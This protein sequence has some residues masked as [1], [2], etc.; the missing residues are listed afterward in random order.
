MPDRYWVGGTA[1]WDNTVG[2]K[3]SATPGGAGGASVPTSAD[4]VFFD[5]ASGAAVVGIAPGN[6]GARSINCT[7]FT[8]T[9]TGSTNITVSGSITLVAAMTWTHSGI[10]TISGTGTL[11]T[12]G[13]LFS[14][15]TINGAGITVTLGG[16]LDI[17]GRNLTVSQG[18]FTTNGNSITAGTLIS[19]TTSVRTI[20]LGA[21][22]LTL[23]NGVL[24]TIP[25]NLTFNAGTSTINITGSSTV[26]D[27][28]GR[29]FNNVTINATS[30][31][32]DGSNTIANLTVVA[33]ATAGFS[34]IS[35]AANALHT[36]T[37]L[38]T[39]GT[40]GNR[41]V[42]LRSAT[43]GISTRLVVNSASGLSDLD[44]RDIIVSG[45]AAPISG[46]R[47][48]DLRGNGG[49]TFSA[50]KTVFRLGTGNW[51]DNQWATASG[52]G[53]TVSTNNFPLAQDTAVFDQNTTIGTH[54][55]NSA[56]PY[57]GTVDMSARTTALTLS[58]GTDITVY[59]NWIN[60]SGITLS[61][62]Q[63][64]TFSGRNTQT[65]T[66][67]G[68][69]FSGGITVDT[70]GGTVVLDG[71]LNIGT[72]NLTV[73]NGTFD[74]G[75]F[76]ITAGALSSS[77]SNV[78]SILLRGSTITLSVRTP[79][80]LTTTAN[81]TFDAGQSQINISYPD[82]LDI[83]FNGSG[84]V[85]YDV[86][87]TNAD[88]QN[89][90]NING[91]N[92]F[93]NLTLPPPSPV[94]TYL[95]ECIVTGN[96]TVLGTL[97]CAGSSVTNRVFLRSDVIGT[98][99]N[100]NVATLVA[101]DCDFRDIAITG[102]A[103]GTAPTRAGDCQGNS[104]IT[105][106]SPK[107]VYWNRTG[108][109]TWNSN[110]WA[111]TIGGAVSLNNFPLAQ[112]T[113]VFTN[114]GAPS[115]LT[116][117]LYNVGSVDMSALTSALTIGSGSY[118]LI[119]YGNFTW[120]QSVTFAS[121][122]TRDYV[123]AG[124]GL[125]NFT[126]PPALIP[127]N[128][129]IDCVTGTLRLM[130]NLTMGSGAI[131]LTLTSGTFDAN[132]YNVTVSNFSSS[133]SL[134]RTLLMG[135][136]TWTLNSNSALNRTTWN[137]GTTTNLTFN[138]G[139]ANIV[140]ENNTTFDRT[141]GGGGL[142]YNKLTIAGTS[143]A[144][145]IILGNN[146]FTE[147]AST[148]TV[149]HTIALGT[150]A[151][152]F[153]AWTVTGTAGNVVTL[154]GTGTSHTIAGAAT[155]GINYLA[156]GAIGFATNSPGEFYA[157]A[158]STGTAGA[159]VFRTAPP[160]PRTL[161]WVGGTG[162]WNATARWSLATG[163]TGG[164]AIPTS[165]DNVIFNSASNASAYTV[166]LNVVARC[167][168]LTIAGPASGNL[169]LAGSNPNSLIVHGNTVFPATGFTR[170]FTSSIV[171]SGS[172]TG[173]TFAS[174]GVSFQGI[175]AD[176][177]VVNGVGAGW[178]MSDSLNLGNNAGLNL[179]NGT[180]STNNFPLTTANII[181]SSGNSKTLN[182][183]SSIVTMSGSSGAIQF[184]STATV[185]NLF[186][187]NAGTST[188]NITVLNAS[189]GNNA[190]PFYD[191]SIA[192]SVG[193]GTTTIGTGTFRNLTFGA[194]LDTGL[195]NI[196]V[197]G[198]ITVTGTLAFTAGANAT[199]RNFFRADTIGT[200]RTITAA[201]FSGTDVDFR[202]ITITG[203]AAPVS[204]TRLGDCKGNSGIT[205]PAGVNKFWNLAIGGNWSATAWATA[206]GGTPNVNN[207]PLAQDTCIFQATGLNSST[208][209]TVDQAFNIGTVDMSARTAS[210]PL[211]I[212]VSPSI[213]GNWINGTGT[214]LSG[215]GTI[216]FVGRTTQTITSASRPFTQ[217]FNISGPS[218]AATSVV[219]LDALTL[220][221]ITI[222]TSGSLVT[223]S[224]AVNL[225]SFFTAGGSAFGSLSM[226]TSTITLS[227]SGG[228]W[229]VVSPAFTVTGAGT[230]SLTS[231]SAKTFNGG[232]IAYTDITLNQGGAGALTITGNN[233][234]R[235]IT[236]TQTAS[237]AASILLGT[238]TQTLSR[239]TGKGES[240]RLLTIQGTSAASPCALVL[241]RTGPAT[242][243][244]VNFLNLVGVR[245]YLLAD[246][247]YAG[248]NST[249]GGTL[250]W[251]F[252]ITPAAFPGNGNFYLMFI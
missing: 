137:L 46:T 95:K 23:S 32:V 40:A 246:T 159:P 249:N 47:I 113:A 115:T 205:F 167:N 201:T 243:S 206:G 79:L 252:A 153:G 223:N 128:L 26:L 111:A 64:L 72:N 149:A 108:S 112:D 102:S 200:T 5:A 208:I 163:G 91:S 74:T 194:P 99:R 198:D 241:D 109:Q 184:G 218:G 45:T 141:F 117:E 17:T 242:N 147:L 133:G 57:C 161:Y 55:M 212:G 94:N 140:F 214:T 192:S 154:T 68:R 24:F 125:S 43:Y 13:K 190:L 76:E 176:T 21:S 61:G 240:G 188:V 127:Y 34:F 33:P 232:D 219:L 90:I 182:L 77:N 132:G 174:N 67:A 70:Y 53:G 180:F 20:N 62:A 221:A 160:A 85:Y 234:F 9:I 144:I 1:N 250:G 216:T 114:T 27:G 15:T 226:G 172:T 81:L 162:S 41:R 2:T 156:M 28:G 36:I 84:L 122:A 124:R 65:I 56:I 196:N 80:V 120:A 88:P 148:K 230:I 251:I 92:T 130:S 129:T 87:F 181:A 71:P 239:F 187:F 118:T 170:T 89:L 101:S 10:V 59:G 58:L 3:W 51:S 38:A 48:G 6:T 86:N 231:A 106:P 37:A 177:M 136:G 191:V 54:T 189:F 11:T 185:R 4:D 82:T 233:R 222:T 107:T 225:S 98:T 199:R 22:T 217:N 103:A 236:A 97:T 104:G 29:T 143:T 178:S 60:G 69:T 183:G 179:F 171:L 39:S 44:F 52:A 169:T 228:A 31:G 14:P 35:F 151:Q 134:N 207:F 224:F 135:S 245:A 73:T 16:P 142:A 213:H 215:T 210:T 116:I 158:N 100:L 195:Q 138:K 227:V 203:A 126:A 220:P 121:A 8:G 66:G 248:N 30:C 238:T 12:A 83:N 63:V 150:T 78:R 93:N 110:S 165:L 119:F 164:E 193:L 175:S 75:G 166:T 229:S 157:G 247:W 209:V 42:W 7:G 152:Q 186:T 204:G 173:K 237:S 49:I 235:D 155:S 105:F 19:Q 146:S 96:Q 145:T 50:P 139:T 197:T 168:Q 25:D 131:T 123:Y 244:A 202:D 18:T 211:V